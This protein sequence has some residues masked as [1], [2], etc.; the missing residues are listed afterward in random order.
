MGWLYTSRFKIRSFKSVKLVWLDTVSGSYGQFHTRGSYA[1]AVQHPGP[2]LS[3]YASRTAN[4]SLVHGG[5]EAQNWFH[6]YDGA[7]P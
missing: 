4:R 5:Q 6:W 3:R 7:A 2:Q 1:S